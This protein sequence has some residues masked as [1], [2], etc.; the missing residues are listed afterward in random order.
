MTDREAIVRLADSVACLAQLVADHGT[1]STVLAERNVVLD[2]IRLMAESSEPAAPDY[3]PY[4]DGGKFIA[5]EPAA[6]TV[7]REQAHFLRRAVESAMG[8]E[9]MDIPDLSEMPAFF[10]AVADALEGE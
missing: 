7:T 5:D 4:E 10:R 8:R 6:P 3:G 2:L 9:D 1:R